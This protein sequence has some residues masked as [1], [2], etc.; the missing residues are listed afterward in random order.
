MGNTYIGVPFEEKDQVKALGAKWDQQRRSWFVPEGVDLEPFAR[1]F[2]VEEDRE[3]YI[4]VARRRCWDCGKRTTVVAL[5][6]PY[7]DHFRD[8]ADTR[9]GDPALRDGAPHIIDS[10]GLI[11]RL[12]AMPRE[13]RNHLDLKY[14]Y[15]LMR[16]KTTGV[17]ELNNCCDHCGALQG[18][19]FDF[20][21]P[22]GAFFP[23]AESDLDD[24]EFFR[25]HT[26]GRI[27]GSLNGCNS[28]DNSLYRLARRKSKP[29][30]LG[31]FENIYLP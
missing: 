31:I 27:V 25:T 1:W 5:G 12:G 4:V 13:L 19:H 6:I 24:L 26:T 7:G 9:G 18:E 10:L 21:E 29:L 11:P 22:G 17:A 15:R 16:S 23:F 30:P 28:L 20:H 3:F 8:M 2:E 14:A